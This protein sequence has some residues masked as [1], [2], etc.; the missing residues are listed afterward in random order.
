[1]DWQDSAGTPFLAPHAERR[2][3]EEMLRQML[4]TVGV[5]HDGLVVRTFFAKVGPDEDKVTPIS[6]DGLRVFVEVENRST[7][8]ARRI[9]V[10]PPRFELPD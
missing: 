2:E 8:T 3:A 9:F 10:G 1:M 6:V 4:L 7:Q 5:L